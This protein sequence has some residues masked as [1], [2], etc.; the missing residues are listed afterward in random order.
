MQHTTQQLIEALNTASKL[1]F[2]PEGYREI[3]LFSQLG[4]D[5]EDYHLANIQNQVMKRTACALVFY[6]TVTNEKPKL[7]TLAQ[8][9]NITLVPYE[10]MKAYFSEQAQTAMTSEVEVIEQ[11]NAEEAN[12]SDSENS[13]SDLFLFNRRFSPT[14]D[15][16]PVI[17][18]PQRIVSLINHNEELVQCAAVGRAIDEH[19][20]LDPLMICLL[21]KEI[22]LLDNALLLR[23]QHMTKIY[24][25][26]WVTQTIRQTQVSNTPLQAKPNV[27]MSSPVSQATL[28]ALLKEYL[29]FYQPAKTINWDNG[30]LF[31]C[32]DEEYGYNGEAAQYTRNQSPFLPVI[33]QVEIRPNSKVSSPRQYS[34]II[35]VKQP[36]LMSWNKENT[37]D[38]LEKIIS[39]MV[40]V[41]CLKGKIETAKMIQAA[42]KINKSCTEKMLMEATAKRVAA[43]GLTEE[44]FQTKSLVV[45]SWDPDVF[46]ILANIDPLNKK[47]LNIEYAEKSLDPKVI[48]RPNPDPA[49]LDFF[50]RVCF[51]PRDILPKKPWK[52]GVTPDHLTQL[53]TVQENYETERV[54]RI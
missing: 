30:I 13:D 15:P 46:K 51:F 1:P 23:S 29:P 14:P 39:A 40:T 36:A 53:R 6:D 9:K 48:K 45:K 47:P 34:Y 33:Y 2:S 38:A 19:L 41:I 3:F 5:V 21:C 12:Q 11:S 52:Q 20:L 43:L 54:L 28:D 50:E 7:K 35:D 4:N 31:N 16:E 8:A 25:K 37:Y 42:R 18:V 10:A 27:F 24:D 22:G 44:D 26:D 32:I 17:P 49:S